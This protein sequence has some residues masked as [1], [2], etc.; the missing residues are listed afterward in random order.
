MI[1]LTQQ[2][3]DPNG[4][5]SKLVFEDENGAIAE[6]VV[7]RYQDRGVVCFSVQSG[8]PVGC[9]FCGTGRKF[10]RDLTAEEI[11]LQID[12]GHR[13]I[14]D[15]EKQQYMSMSMGEPMLN[16]YA[17]QEAIEES[18]KVGIT[19]THFY[20][21]T[22]GIMDPAVLEEILND[23]AKLAHFGLQ[24]S[25]HDT[26]DYTRWKLLGRY[27]DLMTIG[28]IKL[29]AGLWKER[30]VKPA[31]FNYICRR[32]PAPEEIDNIYFITKGHHLTLSVLCNTKD[33]AKGDPAPAL[34][35][36]EMMLERHPDQDVSVFDPAGQDT[37]GGGCGQLL[38]VQER[39]KQ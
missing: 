30:T 13:M 10:I 6:S 12:I 20:I 7:Y 3:D 29:A 39:L 5:V 37:I 8:C 26:S 38:Y 32:K 31:Y 36:S 27:K 1:K 15:R 21:S 4:L 25:L 28:Q 11:L 23:G 22:V 17:L 9:T 24:F 19:S 18:P 14:A 16:Y 34:A 33:F 35:F 2:F